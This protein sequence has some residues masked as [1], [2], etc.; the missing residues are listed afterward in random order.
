MALA[1]ARWQGRWASVALPAL[2]GMLA[3]PI[4]LGLGIAG[5]FMLPSEPDLATV[6]APAGIG[7]VL[8]GLLR[9]WRGAMLAALALTVVFAGAGVAKL[10]SDHV[11][12]PVLEKRIGPRMVDGRVVTVER[13]GNGWRMVLDELGIGRLKTVPERAR[14]TTR[15][16]PAPVGARVRVRAVLQPPPQPAAPGAFNFARQAW[17]QRLGGVG[18]AI[19]P[20]RATGVAPAGPD[21]AALRLLIGVRV[22]AALPGDAGAL[23]AALMTGDRGAISAEHLDAMRD[24]GLAHLLA[25]SGLHIGLFSGVVFFVV[26][27]GLALWPALAVRWPIKK[28]AAVAALLAAGAYMLLT[29]ASVPTQRA[30]VMVAIV[31]LAVLAD[32]NPLSMRLVAVAAT[33]ILLLRP[34]SLLSVSFQ[35]SFAAVVCLIAAYEA[36]WP[37]L[38]RWRRETGWWGRPTVYVGGIALSTLV[39]GTATA[40]FALIH[41]QQTALYGLAANLVAVPATALWIMPAALATFLALPFGLEAAPL[42]VMQFG[43]D[44]VL[45]TAEAVAAWPGAVM[46]VAASPDWVAAP[47]AAGALLVCLLRGWPRWLGV[48]VLLAGLAFVGSVRPPDL[49]VD[50]VAGLAATRADDGLAFSRPARGFV[51]E[52]WSRRAGFAPDQRSERGW[53]CDGL[54]CVWPPDEPVVSHVRNEQALAEDC[55]AVPVIISAEPV[56]IRCPADVVIDRFD[57]WRHGPHALY[58]DGAGWRVETVS[59]SLG[60]R[61]WVRRR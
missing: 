22:R 16:D 49:L 19:G 46:R 47:V 29:G 44:T 53:R 15:G 37:R 5:Y 51:A 25:I 7:A 21:L 11:A 10:R 23:A 45:G 52:V 59:G 28:W 50:D 40:P 35:M 2:A 6:L 24:S 55:A 43:L 26:R 30:F 31:F 48:P 56:R 27:A 20:V 60:E 1:E 41:F 42:W 34:E 12:A 4:L 38:M 57:V 9:R 18:Y 39:A 32:R 13:R 61:P 36:G 17:F 58:R 33:A 8:C 3:L 54:A 14:L